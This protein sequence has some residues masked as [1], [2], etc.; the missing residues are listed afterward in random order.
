MFTVAVPACC[1][2]LFACDFLLLPLT[3]LPVHLQLQVLICFTNKVATSQLWWIPASHPLSAGE[4]STVAHGA[5]HL[6]FENYG[7]G[8]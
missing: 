8:Q 5:M 7:N 4:E 1:F 3:P 6:S 2:E